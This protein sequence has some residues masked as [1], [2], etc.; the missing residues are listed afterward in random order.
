MNAATGDDSR[1][2][3]EAANPSTPWLT[4][5]H[6]IDTVLPRSIINVATGTY[7]EDLIVPAGKDNLELKPDTGA[8][9]TIK[10]V[11]QSAAAE[12]PLARPNI[13]LLGNGTKIHGFTIEGPN[14]ASGYYSSGI[15]IGGNDIEI[16]DNTFNV[17]TAATF[18]EVSQAIQTY[19]DGNN[20]TGG[21][22]SGLNIHENTFTGL[23]TEAAGY[24]A[25]F[26]NHTSADPDPTGT[27]TIQGNTFQ[28]DILRA[29]T[30]E[31]SK[32]TISGNSIITDLAPGSSVGN[33]R[34]GILVMD[35][36][37]RA[38]DTVTVTGN[39]VKGSAP[40]N[41]FGQGIRIGHG[42]GTQPLTN[43]SVTQNTVQMN[44]KGI[45]VRASAGGVVVNDNSISGNTVYGV[46]NT[47]TANTLDAEYNWWGDASG[48]YNVTTNPTGT[49]DPVSDYVDYTPWLP[50][51][52]ITFPVD[53]QSYNSGT[54]STISG[55]ASGGVSGIKKVEVNIKDTTG[56]GLWWD[57]GN[58]VGSETWVDATGTD[59]WTYNL[60]SGNL[61]VGH[62]YLVQ[63]RATDNDS[64]VE[65][66]G[67]GHSFS[68]TNGP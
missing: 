57:G 36:D 38:Q 45:Q 44:D 14:P 39:T 26:I 18:A 30:T 21:D 63:S 24:E 68:Y 66:P 61:T 62:S 52:S 27:V 16:Y 43:I 40:G 17:P 34:N 65:I 60:A 20:P 8:A 31:R 37:A 6:A 48:P 29:I 28:G 55:T 59:S 64:N 13:E 25:I 1:T 54:W 23:G 5:Q 11:Q 12:W 53:G 33:A 9:V 51:S 3:K 4:I 46:E 35:F 50:T 56:T 41:G 58:W 7:T 42:G 67:V 2:A 19:R 10:G 32:T 49:G 47:D 22:V 15:V